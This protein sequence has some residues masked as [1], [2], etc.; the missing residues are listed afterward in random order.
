MIRMPSSV[1]VICA[2][3]TALVSSSSLRGSEFIPKP[4]TGPGPFVDLGYAK[5]QGSTDLTTNISSFL[6]I[7][8]AAPPIGEPIPGIIAATSYIRCARFITVSSTS[9][10]L[11]D[12]TPPDGYISSSTMLSSRWRNVAHK[13]FCSSS[14]F[15]RKAA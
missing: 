11:Q 4:R 13:S 10:A 12:G 5:Y 15:I 8:Y 3:F 6:S 2:L 9:S 14:F 1:G 7:R